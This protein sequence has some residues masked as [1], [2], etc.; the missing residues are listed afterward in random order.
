MFLIT[1]NYIYYM[2]QKKNKLCSMLYYSSMHIHCTIACP[3][4]CTF[5]SPSS[6]YSF[7]FKFMYF[8]QFRL[9]TGQTSSTTY[10]SFMLYWNFIAKIWNTLSFNII[11]LGGMEG[12]KLIFFL[13]I[14]LYILF[15]I[16]RNWRSTEVELTINTKSITVTQCFNKKWKKN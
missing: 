15:L 6:I 11:Y 7:R 13:Y 12:G 3:V 16:I 1:W 14:L 2:I 8:W 10:F 5:W 9:P 4:S